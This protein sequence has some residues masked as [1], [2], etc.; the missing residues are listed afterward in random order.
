MG[1][2]S[3]LKEDVYFFSA[4]GL[5][6]LSAPE[7]LHQTS[8]GWVLRNGTNGS[9]SVCRQIA[10]GSADRERHLD[11]H[12][13]D[14]RALNISLVLASETTRR[15]CGRYLNSR[16][17]AGAGSGGL[18]GILALCFLGGLILNIMPCVF[19]VLAIKVL[20]FVKQSGAERRRVVL[21]GLMFTGGVLVS[22]WALVGLLLSLR[23]GGAQ[24]GW[25]F[26]LQQPAFVLG[27][28][29]FFFAV[30]T[31]FERGV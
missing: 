2:P 31:E 22:M 6:Q 12:R 8:N 11:E 29:I 23:A 19:P 4:D 1:V 26:Q 18:L 5:T 14:F 17:M 24:L 9:G 25:G 21:H 16:V 3:E 10:R 28:A 15:I 30:R 27:L 13:S 20:G 7:T